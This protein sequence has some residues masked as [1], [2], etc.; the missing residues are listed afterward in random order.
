MSMRVLATIL[1]VALLSASGA[2]QP[3]TL[4][5]WTHARLTEASSRLGIVLVS[6]ADT[7]SLSHEPIPLSLVG[8]FDCD[9]AADAA[10]RVQ[11]RRN[12]RLGILILRRNGLDVLLG[13]GFP[14]GNGGDDFYW[15][16]WWKIASKGSV[17]ESYYERPV[18]LQCDGILTASEGSASALIY[19]DNGAFKWQQQGD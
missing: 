15:L 12:G 14:F 16:D 1:T 3:E 19:F 17:Q 4:P 11:E 10:L 13:A 18:T 5:D 2:A 7:S 6:G 9:G 8:D